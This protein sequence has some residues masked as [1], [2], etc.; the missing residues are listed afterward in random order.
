MLTWLA[1]KVVKTAN[2]PGTVTAC[3]YLCSPTVHQ[4]QTVC[5]F[6][7]YERVNHYG[8]SYHR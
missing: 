2:T 3:L 5:V 1:S 4:Y 6:L 7:T 8:I